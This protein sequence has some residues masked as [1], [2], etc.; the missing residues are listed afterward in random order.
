MVDQ[1]KVVPVK[2]KSVRIDVTSQQLGIL[3]KEV[4]CN[5][6]LSGAERRKAI[7]RIAPLPMDGSRVDLWCEG[8]FVG[9]V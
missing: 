1:N 7:R 3:R 5:Q 6:Q 8:D 4:F 9:T 2:R